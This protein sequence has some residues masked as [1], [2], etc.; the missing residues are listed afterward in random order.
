MDH[1]LHLLY[2]YYYG[3]V[4]KCFFFILCLSIKLYAD[5]IKD[6]SWEIPITNFFFSYSTSFNQDPVDQNILHPHS[7]LI[8][9]YMERKKIKKKNVK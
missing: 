4:E 7:L 1:C 8:K 3:S 2:T 6:F 5:K 9:T